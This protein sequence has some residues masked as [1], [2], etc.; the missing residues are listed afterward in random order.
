MPDFNFK[1]PS[2]LGQV[3]SGLMETYFG[4]LLQQQKIERDQK[5]KDQAMR[6]AAFHALLQHPDTPESDIPNILDMVAKEA[7]AEKDFAPVT[8]HI[9]A[10][11]QR[12][13]PTG[14]EQETAQSISDRMTAQTS[15][16][17]T[18]SDIAPAPGGV[19][20]QIAS[21]LAPSPEPAPSMFQPTAEYGSLSQSEAE[22]ARKMEQ[23]RQQ[24]AIQTQKMLEQ[25]KA[26]TDR[27][28]QVET[29]KESS[30][31][32]R[33]ESEYKLKLGLLE[34]KERLQADRQRSQFEQALLANLD[35]PPTEEDKAA[36]RAKSGEMVIS[37]ANSTLA[38]RAAA[39]EASKA[40]AQN[41]LA[42][43]KHWDRQDNLAIQKEATAG[44]SAPAVRMF[45]ANTR[46]IWPELS[47][48][49]S[50][51]I[52]LQTLKSALGS[53]NTT[54]DAQLQ[55]LEDRRDTLQLQIDDARKQLNSTVPTAPVSQG[56][57]GAG[58]PKGMI[59]RSNL[60][61]VRQ[62]NPSLAGMDDNSLIQYL[63]TH[64]YVV[65]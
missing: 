57:G 15:G 11:M 1:Q 50:E 62:Q 55:E 44:L 7:K 16:T 28:L 43:I 10:G 47:R 4:G 64:G 39:T 20:T 9:R 48:T 32:A 17:T 53:T 54:F 59:R 19:P 3:G 31:Q 49:K 12:R 42:Q 24:Q 37:L 26:M 18:S 41:R 38:Q 27:A 45:N 2:Q 33:L 13:V 46:E 25:Q 56:S 61:A 60:G 51:I 63:G 40:T 6:L 35:H 58:Q 14:P 52:R 8:A 21:T 29:A 65:K 23:F 36:A 22:D 5:D 30:R 34:P